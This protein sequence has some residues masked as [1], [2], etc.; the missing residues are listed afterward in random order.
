MY[1]RRLGV[2]GY[3]VVYYLVVWL[4]ARFSTFSIVESCVCLL[5]V[6]CLQIEAIGI[7]ELPT[8]PPGRPS[9]SMDDLAVEPAHDIVLE[10]FAT[11][12][13]NNKDNTCTYAGG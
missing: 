5:L 2:G 8:Q 9:G 1:E 4:V 12:Q 13:R 10:V 11:Y 3:Q 7:G 6:C